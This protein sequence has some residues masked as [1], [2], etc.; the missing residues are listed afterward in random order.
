MLLYRIEFEVDNGVS[1]D[2]DVAIVM[3]HNAEEAIEKLRSLINSIDSETCVSK[4]YKTVIF[5]G[6]VFTGNHGWK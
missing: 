4:I 1:Y 6:E 3:A 5:G 2:K